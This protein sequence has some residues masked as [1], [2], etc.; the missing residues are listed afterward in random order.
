MPPRLAPLGSNTST[1]S[2]RLDGLR[3]DSGAH[4]WVVSLP[5]AGF[6]GVELG[7]FVDKQPPSLFPGATTYETTPPVPLPRESPPMSRNVVPARKDGVHESPT[8][9]LPVG[10]VVVEPFGM[11]YERPPGIITKKFAVLNES[12]ATQKE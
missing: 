5:P 3:Y 9:V 11:A 1:V 4:V 7:L 8:P 10:S 6:P 12:E 2:A